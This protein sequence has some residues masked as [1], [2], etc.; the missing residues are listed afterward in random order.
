MKTAFLVVALVAIVAVLGVGLWR[1]VRVRSLG[2][3]VIL[4]EMP[5]AGAHGWRHG[6]VQYA[7]ETA[8]YYKLRS[9]CP[10]PDAVVDRRELSLDGRR[11][12]T[13]GE[14]SFIPGKLQI[15]QFHHTDGRQWEMVLDHTAEMAFTAWLESAPNR[16]QERID[17]SALMRRISQERRAS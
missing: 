1:F 8:R 14:A 10:W 6:R 16:R 17:L 12:L 9:L 4:R 13:P 2:T 3:P 7:G 11:N 5:A 15:L